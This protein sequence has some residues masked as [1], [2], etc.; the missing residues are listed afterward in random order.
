[1]S[2]SLETGLGTVRTMLHEAEKYGGILDYG[3]ETNFPIRV[4]FIFIGSG[5]FLF[6]LVGI[7]VVDQAVAIYAGLAIFT[8][9]AIVVALKMSL[10][11]QLQSLHKKNTLRAS[12]KLKQLVS[13]IK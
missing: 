1:M 13:E 12:E 11:L 6:Y 8:L 4:F 10:I 5:I 3:K 2:E 7:K 9:V